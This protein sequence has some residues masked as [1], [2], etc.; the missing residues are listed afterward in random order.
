MEIGGYRAFLAEPS[1]AGLRVKKEAFSELK[2]LSFNGF[3]VVIEGY[4]L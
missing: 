2:A 1:E 3:W 4:L